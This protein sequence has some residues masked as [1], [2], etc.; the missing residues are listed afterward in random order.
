MGLESTIRISGLTFSTGEMM[1]YIIITVL[2]FIA[3][4]SQAKEKIE[5]E[6]DTKTEKIKIIS[7][8]KNDKCINELKNESSKRLIKS[9]T[10][11]KKGKV[12]MKFYCMEDFV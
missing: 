1:K 4:E 10:R 11:E 9:A 2:F 3:Q 8:T 5:I 6:Y 12:R 7:S